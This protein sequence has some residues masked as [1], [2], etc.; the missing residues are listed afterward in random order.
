MV[1]HKLTNK[2]SSEPHII[3][4]KLYSE[5][6]TDYIAFSLEFTDQSVN[7]FVIASD[8]EQGLSEGDFKKWQALLLY[9]LIVIE[10]FSARNTINSLLNTYVGSSTGKKIFN[11][12]VKRGDS[13][14]KILSK[15][16]NY[17]QNIKRV[18]G[19]YY[20]DGECKGR[21]CSD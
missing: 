11:G 4:Q 1:R 20:A 17:V 3:L 5:R 2:L 8:N 9:L 15:G 19:V 18:L 10:V 13:E 7:T 16:E 21:A 12:I 14:R 6:A